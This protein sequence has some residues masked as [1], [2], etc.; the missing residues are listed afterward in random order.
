MLASTSPTFAQAAPPAAGV[1]DFFLRGRDA[2][3]QGNYKRAL[4]MFRAS[5]KLSPTEKKL[6]N[7]AR[8]EA[9][10]GLSGSALRHFQE[11]VARLPE[12]DPLRAAIL[13]EVIKLSP[14]VP[15][16][17]ISLAPDAPPGTT[18][19]LDGEPLAPEG[20]GKD[21]PLDPGRHEVTA[22]AP[23]ALTKRYEITVPEGARP[24]LEVAPE[25]APLPIVA[26][27]IAPTLQSGVN[28]PESSPWADAPRN[29]RWKVG[30]AAIGVGGA[31]LI[32]GMATG[33]MAVG[34]HATLADKCPM[35]MCVKG[36]ESHSQIGSYHTL[37]NVS[38]ATLIAG[39]ALVVTGIVLVATSPKRQARAWV[40][41]Q[42]GAGSLGLRGAF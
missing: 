8:T 38:T 33:G 14:K 34:K 7:V 32:A 39:G 12:T 24:S 17:R 4:E 15:Y 35:N 40:A 41:P 27:T 5:Y 28:A 29:T 23:G 3:E 13:D 30:M 20:F 2:F 1:D 19:T 31:S 37:A 11:V 42:I 21:V 25:V 16:L 18:V 9:R 26:P 6:A 36:T 10:L 22:A